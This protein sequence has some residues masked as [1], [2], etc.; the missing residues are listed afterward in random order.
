MASLF[1]RAGSEI[2]SVTFKAWDARRGTWVWRQQ[3]TKTRDKNRAAAIA[4]T[5][6]NG[7]QAAKAGTLTRDKA[8]AMV[9]DILRLAGL[10]ELGP[11]PSLAQIVAEMTDGQSV[12]TSTARKYA[13]MWTAFRAWAGDRATAPVSSWS[14]ADIERYYRSVRG[15][16]STTT[17]N[18]HMNFL[19]MAF[20]RA[21]RYGHI[22]ANP[23][24]AVRRADNDSVEKLTFSRAD[25]AAL[26][27]V[28]RRNRRLDWCA[29]VGLGWH[30]GHRIQDLLGVQPAALQEDAGGWLLTLKP[31]KKGA[32]GREV[33]LPLPAWVARRVRRLGGLQT[34]HGGSNRSGRVSE[35]FV[36]WMRSAGIDPKP[37]KRGPRVVHLRSFH[38]FRH[39]MASRL[40]AA[41]VSGELARLVTDH[42]S[43]QVQRRYV[44]AEI[45]ALRD[46]LRSVRGR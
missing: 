19:S 8:L 18:G 13:S 39:S 2:W 37:I 35:E 6:E 16:L 46:A 1:Q 33:V 41:G 25:T 36:A 5:L 24:D 34:I 45:Q 20:G 15:T 26:L 27:R 23:V 4:A 43:P 29:L 10:E 11:V 17:A 7:A 21:V 22:S 30:T 3:S 14:A 32:K 12:A 31:A 28:L 40:A 42:D 9:N 44:H 38:S